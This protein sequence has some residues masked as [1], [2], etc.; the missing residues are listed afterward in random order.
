[1]YKAAAIR[2]TLLALAQPERAKI[3]QKFFQTGPGQYA[4]GDIFLGLNMPEIHQM[5]KYYA[6]S[7]EL[8]ELGL[9]ITYP[10]HEAR[11][12]AVIILVNQYQD[13][14]LKLENKQAIIDFY[15][16][17]TQYL[18]NWDLVDQS[19][20]KILGKYCF[21]NTQDGILIGLSQSAFLWEE[22]IA[23]VACLH[24][25]KQK[26][27]NLPLAIITQNL[28]HHHAL[29][30]KANGWML[31]EIGKI[32]HQI[33]QDYLNQNIAKM[34]RTTLRYAIERFDESLRQYFLKL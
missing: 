31:R 11:M 7:V 27:T 32:N 19:A 3:L 4:E 2:Q 17:N 24:Y 13:K 6:P 34:P 28:G 10:E 29:M 5:A 23:V 16:N 14:K 12:L 15:L 18:N 22:R 25:I 9:L 21:E 33:L 8:A 30:H 26:N 20:Y 1:M